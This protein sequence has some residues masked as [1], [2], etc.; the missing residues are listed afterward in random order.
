[1][2]ATHANLLAARGQPVT[3]QYSHRGKAMS[4]TGNLVSVTRPAMLTGLMTLTFHPPKRVRVGRRDR[5][6][7]AGRGAIAEP[8]PE[9]CAAECYDGRYGKLVRVTSV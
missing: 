6:E 9:D 5:F 7:P 8:A 3:V 1:M 4:Y 2:D